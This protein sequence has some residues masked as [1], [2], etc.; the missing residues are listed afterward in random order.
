[1]IGIG[2]L[3]SK[4]QF[5]SSIYSTI[6]RISVLLL[7]F[8]MI[9][10]YQLFFFFSS[11]I[12]N[13]FMVQTLSL[14]ITIPFVRMNDFN[15]SFTSS[16]YLFCWDSSATFSFLLRFCSRF[17]KKMGI[18]FFYQ[19]DEDLGMDRKRKWE[20]PNMAVDLDFLNSA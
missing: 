20:F 11:Y 9:F 16:S 13:K 5:F 4:E 14:S 3:F 8:G 15:I 10:Y 19:S 17:E 6:F 7:L 1:M 18:S 12:Y 2:L